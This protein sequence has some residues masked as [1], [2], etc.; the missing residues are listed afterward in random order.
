MV[1]QAAMC[2]YILI[3]MA[4]YWCTDIIPLAV[5]GMIPI[6]AFPLT[7]IMSTTQV[8]EN[9]MSVRLL[10]VGQPLFYAE[11]SAHVKAKMN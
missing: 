11:G 9:Y 1:T 2:G 10:I 8:C 7:G 6:F 4:F 3:I 5:T